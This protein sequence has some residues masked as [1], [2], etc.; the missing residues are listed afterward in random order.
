ML[1]FHCAHHISTAKTAV[2]L[3]DSVNLVTGF[4]TSWHPTS[5]AGIPYF[6]APRQGLTRSAPVYPHHLVPHV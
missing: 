2:Q 6:L 3:G 4:T 5:P 1:F